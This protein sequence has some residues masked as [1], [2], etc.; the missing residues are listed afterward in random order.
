MPRV[1]PGIVLALLLPALGEAN[2]PLTW[3]GGGTEERLR[4]ILDELR[5]VHEDLDPIISDMELYPTEVD[6]GAAE[7]EAERGN[8]QGQTILF[9]GGLRDPERGVHESTAGCRLMAEAQYW[10]R[11]TGRLRA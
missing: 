3:S 9:V 8:E 5:A 10:E 6:W 7:G 1:V 4:A 11:L 2:E